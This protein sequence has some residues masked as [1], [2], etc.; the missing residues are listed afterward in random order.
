M[1]D[2]GSFSSSDPDRHRN[3]NQEKKKMSLTVTRQPNPYC[4]TGNAIT[5]EVLTDACEAIVVD[6]ICKGITQL[7]SYYPFRQGDSYIVRFDIADYLYREA[8]HEDY[9]S[10]QIIAPLDNFAIPFQVKI[11]DDYTFEGT[12]F[13]GGIDNRTLAALAKEGFDIFTYRLNSRFEQFLFTTRTHAKVVRVRESELYPFV[14]IHPGGPVTISSENG[15]T[16]TGFDFPQGTVCMLDVAAVREHFLLTSGKDC[17]TIAVSPA[18]EYAFSV[19]VMP[20]QPSEDR[21]LI[22]FRN[23]LGAFEVVEVVGTATHEPEIGEADTYLTLTN[24]GFYEDRRDRLSLKDVKK[25]ETGYKTKEEILFIRDMVCSDEAYFIYPDGT[26]FRCNVSADQ[27][28]YSHRQTAP[29]S[30][31]LVVTD[32]NNSRYVAPEL[33]WSTLADFDT[34][35]DDSY[36]GTFE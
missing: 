29:T 30:I 22:R 17:N 3:D 9:P 13:K 36:E 34:V 4:F 7:A 33:D 12:A 6:I 32:V 19:Q 35:F 21:Y 2:I 25:V 14:F 15:A 23:S 26:S 11:G 8:D 31:P 10:G 28:K 1:A 18:G 20:N 5:F 16:A 24:H 27:M